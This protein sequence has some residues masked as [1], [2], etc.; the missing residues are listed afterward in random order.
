MKS[1]YQMSKS[2]YEISPD[3]EISEK[4]T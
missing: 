1:N 4:K 2:R 3:I